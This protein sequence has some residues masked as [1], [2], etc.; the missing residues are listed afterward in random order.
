CGIIKKAGNSYSFGEVKLGVGRE[1]AKAALKGDPKLIK[2]I[3]KV[4]LQASKDLALAPVAA[5]DETEE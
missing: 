5:P 2:E 3:E 4:T 1:T